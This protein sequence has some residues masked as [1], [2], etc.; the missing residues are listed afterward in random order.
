MKREKRVVQLNDSQIQSNPKKP[1]EPPTA[2]WLG[3]LTKGVGYCQS[4]GA[5]GEKEPLCAFG[6]AAGAY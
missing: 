4:G 3:E 2:V 1:Y 5:P 6:A